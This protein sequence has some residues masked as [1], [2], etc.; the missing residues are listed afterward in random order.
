MSAA[1]VEPLELL[2]AFQDYIAE[3]D[4][5]TTAAEVEQE[6]AERKAGR[7][8]RAAFNVCLW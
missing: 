8:A 3:Q 1:D 5:E 7:L 4:K 2:M 6:A